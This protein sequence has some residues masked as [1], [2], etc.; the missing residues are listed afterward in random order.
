MLFGSTLFML[1]NLFEDSEPPNYYQFN[2]GYR[3][4]SKD[5]ITWNYY[6][7]LG[8]PYGKKKKAENFP[9]KVEA[10]GIGIAYKRFLWKRA[11]TQIHSTAF[12]QKYLDESN[13]KIQSGFQLFN[14]LRVGYQFQFFKN[15]LF[16]EPSIACTFWPINTELPKSFQIEED[17]Y[18]NFFLP[19]PG[20]HFGFNF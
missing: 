19:E 18:D 5:V 16:V 12:K 4:T 6:E 10:L 3:I 17:K 9:G 13:R 8:I 2:I 20:L 7:P 15:R 11:F 1:A 14:T